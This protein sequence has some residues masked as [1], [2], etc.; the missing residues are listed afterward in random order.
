VK[1]FADFYDCS[2]GDSDIYSFT[3]PS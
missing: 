2:T 1:V 3:N